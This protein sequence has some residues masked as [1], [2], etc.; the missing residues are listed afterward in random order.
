MKT[1]EPY[2]GVSLIHHPTAGTVLF[3]APADSFKAVKALCNHQGFSFP[4]VLVAPALLM[5]DAVAQFSPEFFLYDFLF[6]YGAAF[7]PQLRAERLTI[8]APK[9]SHEK[10][11]L[12]LQHTLVGPS[13]DE[14]QCYAHENPGAGLSPEVIANL[15]GQSEHLAIKRDGTI[16]RIEDMVRFLSLDQGPISLGQ[17]AM[18]AQAEEGF[19]I[20]VGDATTY[21][22]SGVDRKVEPF[23]TLPSPAQPIRPQTFG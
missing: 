2:P 6:V 11:R 5:A 17:E 16:W 19:V 15:V 7:R 12:A 9:S 1:F 4:R 22:H 20:T 14:L 8:V 23:A 10:M 13:K 3:G 18:V 21:V